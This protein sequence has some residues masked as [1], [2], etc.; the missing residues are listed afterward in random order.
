M[1]L[2]ERI[3]RRSLFFQVN[4]TPYDDLGEQ[5]RISKR[6]RIAVPHQPAEP[7]ATDKPMPVKDQ[8]FLIALQVVV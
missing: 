5:T 6:K 3:C 2:F 4:T 7:A 1:N 8:A